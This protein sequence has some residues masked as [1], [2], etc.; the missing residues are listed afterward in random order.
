[1]DVLIQGLGVGAA[2]LILGALRDL[3]GFWLLMLIHFAV[4]W[5]Y[6][7]VCE[8][9]FKGQSIGKRIF[10]IRV[11]MSNGAPVKAG[12]S[13][14]RNLLR[15]A[16]AFM[17][18]YLAGLLSLCLSRG[19]RRIGDWAADTLVVY[20]SASRPLYRIAGG[21]PEVPVQS[22]ASPLSYEEKQA[23]LDFARRRPLLGRARADEIA[24]DY[25]A[26][27]SAGTSPAEPGMSSP[28]ISS[29]DG[30]GGAEYLL[31]VA[32]GLSGEA[33]FPAGGKP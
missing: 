6:H 17:F 28:G 22:P 32:R 31:G 27:L 4:V 18:L 10:G 19:F 9:F 1:V 11:V 5:F 30:F 23:I 7:V 8:C 13:F 2:Y 26:C 16:D 24:G 20:I 33:L 21:M 12:A 15:S 25:A 3:V 14:A 29:G